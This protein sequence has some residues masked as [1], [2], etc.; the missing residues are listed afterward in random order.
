M[1]SVFTRVRNIVMDFNAVK[2]GLS[3]GKITLIDVRNPGELE[4]DGKIPG[5]FN[6]PC[7]YLIKYPHVRFLVLPLIFLIICKA[8]NF[9][10]F[11]TLSKD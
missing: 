11:L 3:G 8:P 2:E 6:V 5:S 9:F 1:R 4:S 7:K 10:T